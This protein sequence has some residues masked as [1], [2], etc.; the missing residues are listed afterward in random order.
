MDLNIMI[1]NQINKFLLLE[2]T[3]HLIPQQLQNEQVHDVV[4]VDTLE[5]YYLFYL[6]VLLVVFLAQITSSAVIHIP[7]NLDKNHCNFQVDNNIE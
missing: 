5:E 7:C 6:K 2:L 3:H 1:L 4:L